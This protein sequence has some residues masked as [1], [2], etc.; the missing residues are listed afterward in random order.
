M[1]Q[2]S[3]SGRMLI[4]F[5]RN[6]VL[7][8][9]KTRLGAET[10][11]ET[12]L[13][14]YRK[15]RELTASVTEACSAERAAFYS[16]EIPDADCFLRGGTLAFL[17]EGSDL[18]ERMLHA[19]ETGFAGGFGHIALIGTDC[20]DLQTSI[21]EQAFTELEKHDAVLGPAKDGGFYLIGLNKSHPEL[22]LDRSWSHSRVLQETIDRLN[23]YGTT[24]GLLPELQDID[25]LED[26][27]QSRL[28][29]AEMTGSLSII[30][31]TFNEETGI[32]RML[33]NLLALTDRFDDVEIIVSDSGTDRTAEIV[34]A[35]PVTLCRS[36]KGRARQMNAGAKL[37]R[38]HTLY[39]LHADT[40]PPERFVD[41]ILDAVGSGKEAG[42]FRMQFDDPHPIMTLF[43]WFTRV[44]LSI[45]RGGD[46]SLFITRE[47]FD[48]LGGF[49]EKMQ[50]MEDI[51]IIERIERRGTF[52]IL[53]NHVVTSA[54]KYHKNGIL[55]L[56]A[57][58]GTIHLM[59][60]LGY[61]QES[62]IC[63]YQE[64]IKS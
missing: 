4:V 50:V 38:H 9:V 36:E 49:D 55:R 34:S 46:Q 32:A 18:G 59:Y 57:I 53:D 42:C 48:A 12:A 21:L 43:G 51:D 15:L 31:P 58:F 54:R 52:H 28:R 64:N 33:D 25:T 39:F 7:G 16:D 6:P 29:S 2:E 60:A 47:L 63:Y 1:K 56:Q 13:R 14:V 45:C 17:Q 62:I 22:F 26:L 44:P 23:E 30:I 10:G 40:L 35:F 61:D 20:P 11:P 27:R 8:R 3:S 19:F 37:A 5:T 24:F 41:D